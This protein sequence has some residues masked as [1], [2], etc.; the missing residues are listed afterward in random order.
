[1]TAKSPSRMEMEREL[2]EAAMELIEALKVGGNMRRNS[3]AW[4]RIGEAQSR[5]A[6]ALAA[7]ERPDEVVVARGVYHHGLDMVTTT[8]DANAPTV[9]FNYKDHSSR[10]VLHGQHVAVVVRKSEVE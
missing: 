9:A 4:H 7:R 5:L 8:N 3:F 1:M 6:A 10:R 2:R